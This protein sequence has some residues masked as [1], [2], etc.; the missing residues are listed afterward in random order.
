M[1]ANFRNL[2][3]WAY[4]AGVVALVGG[5]IVAR[6]IGSGG[7]DKPSTPAENNNV[8]HEVLSPE[9]LRA[10][11]ELQRLTQQRDEL[12]AR[13]DQEREEFNRRMGELET[14]SRN[15]RA[16]FDRRL[17]EQQSRFKEQIDALNKLIEDLKKQKAGGTTPAPQLPD[18]GGNRGPAKPQPQPQPIPRDDTTPRNPTPPQPPPRDDSRPP[19]QPPKPNPAVPGGFEVNCNGV[20]P[21]PNDHPGTNIGPWIRGYVNGEE[22]G[23][24]RAIAWSIEGIG[25]SKFIDIAQKVAYKENWPQINATRRT[26]GLKPLPEA[27]FHQLNYTLNQRAG[28]G[29][30]KE[31]QILDDTFLNHLWFTYHVPY[32]C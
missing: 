14:G 7:G 24:Q 23:R 5:F 3:P 29:L 9:A 18:K 2:P 10:Q 20:M 19:P 16:D 17:G 4:A 13:Q 15:E 1:L 31:T 22:R 26:R 30:R 27:A 25:L 28:L 6:R 21:R 11:E 8:V 12:L 32:L